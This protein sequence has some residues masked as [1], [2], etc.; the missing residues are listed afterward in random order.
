MNP[1]VDSEMFTAEE[2][3]PATTIRDRVGVLMRDTDVSDPHEMA[4]II[5]ADLS[6]L[7][8]E[9]LLEVLAE[10]LPGH[11]RV[12]FHGHQ[13]IRT[14]SHRGGN[15]HNMHEP[16]SGL[17]IPSRWDRI[18]TALREP[19]CP[20]GEWKAFGDCTHADLL[21]LIEERRKMA[22]E[23]NSKAERYSEFARRM[24]KCGAVHVRDLPMKDIQEVLR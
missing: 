8:R 14:E 7:P 12:C 24:A 11:V 10:M 9:S 5:L 3:C 21:L 20:G 22:A 1:M 13:V 6:D 18:S 15:G 16:Q 19:I 23:C 17:A 4:E 2:Q